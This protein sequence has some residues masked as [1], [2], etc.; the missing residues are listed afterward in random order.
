[1]ADKEV[2]AILDRL[3]KSNSH[4]VARA[5][6]TA[7]EK[8][9]P[10]PIDLWA[11]FE[12]PTLP[13][14]LLPETIE[15]FAVD[16]GELMGADPAGLAVS[17]LVVCAAAIPDH[18]ELQV[19]EHD[20]S[21]KESARIWAALIGEPSTKKSPILQRATRAL[22]RIDRDLSKAYAKARAEYDALPADERRAK[23]PPAHK[24]AR[25]EDTTIEAA[26]AVLKDNPE[27]VLCA[28]DE[29]SGWFGSMD[30]YTAGRGAAKDRGFWLQAY[31]G[32][33]YSVDRISRGPCAI[34]N[35]SVCVLGGIQPGPLRRLAE[36]AVDDGL[37]QRL[38]PLILQQGRESRDEQKP[39]SAREYEELVCQL[40]H[41]MTAAVTLVFDPAAQAIRRRLERKHLDLMKI[42]TLNKKLAAH[43]GKY[44]G[45]FAR[46]CVLWH[47]IEHSTGGLIDPISEDVARRVERFLHEFL[48][49]HAV[50]F[51]SGTL[52]LSDDHDRLAAVAGYILARQL[53]E[54][55]SRD[56]QRGDRTMRGLKG[57]QTTAVFEQL[58]ALGWLERKPG[59][60]AETLRW[61]VNPKCHEK[62]AARGEREAR[63]R[64]E[65]REIIG[66]VLAP[67]A[68]GG[69]TSHTLAAKAPPE[70]IW[71][72]SRVD[73]VPCV[74]G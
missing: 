69:D 14:G 57:P 13:A 32:G 30:K 35:L 29:L 26:Q 66:I 45:L 3:K 40:R 27:G 17:A 51:Y 59:R 62:F 73:I 58:E 65:A 28:Q 43:V 61:Q 52:G 37:I 21:W 50:A 8:E 24:R 25:L 49:P 36:E 44:D 16:Q 19:K 55:T 71:G 18:I 41:R 31:N 1:M 38:I 23:Q 10:L 63:R 22:T 33:Y 53:A 60:Y 46:L 67:E 56:V 72:N 42:E 20:P 70:P 39:R 5:A 15:R 9:W 4:A 2:M 12:P 64:H 48:F 34:E 74:R 54:V 6:D 7:P 47:C 68:D 11:R